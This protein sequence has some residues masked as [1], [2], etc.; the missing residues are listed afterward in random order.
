MQKGETFE[1]TFGSGNLD[2]IFYYLIMCDGLIVDVRDNSGGLITSAEKLAA[3]F[4]NKE[5]LVGYLRHKTGKGHQDF[6]QLEE[7]RLKPASGMRWQKPVV[8]LTNRSVYSAANE[9]VK[10][11]RCCPQTTI[12]GD[13]TGGGAGM[14][15]TSELPIGWSV[16]FSACPM[17]DRNGQSTEDGIDPDVNVALSQADVLRGEDTLIEQARRLIRQGKAQQ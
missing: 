8:V 1:N 2:E 15:F 16:R 11:M 12:L 5:I 13:R 6:S 3:R 14:P 9:F 7:Q 4:T 17:Y 10:Y